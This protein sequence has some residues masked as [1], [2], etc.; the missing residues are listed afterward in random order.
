MATKATDL[1]DNASD[2]DEEALDHTEGLYRHTKRPEWGVAILA[3]EKGE[4]RAYQFED[5]RLRKFKAGYY[6]L[7]E[8][9]GEVEREREA[10][11]SDLEDAIEA[12][13]NTPKPEALDPVATFDAQ[14]KLFREMYPGGFKDPEWIA[15]HRG[16]T[17]GRTLK[18][19]REPVMERA[20]EELSRER[21]E[22]L[23]SEG[24]HDEL[25]E[26]VTDILGSTSLVARKRVKILEEL[27]EDMRKELAEAVAEMLHGEGEFEEGFGAFLEV[28]TK[29]FDGAPSW[30]IAT[31]LPALMYPGEHVCVRRSAFIR[32]AAAVSPMA[33]YSRRAEVKSYNN[34]RRVALAVKKR[35]DAVDLEPKDML[36]IHDFVWAT[37]R[38]ASLDD[39]EEK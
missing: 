29:I 6:S 27:D 26:S 34:F 28:L 18:R 8:P 37:L 36:D 11:V 12:N 5:G 20:Q 9:A 1:P 33:S 16:N 17:P 4:R 13:R 15:E 21:C 25:M 30:R 39:L 24:K 2:V 14:V 38:N 31:A 22:E 19:H 23:L 10:V 7:F 32:Q 35:L 3:W